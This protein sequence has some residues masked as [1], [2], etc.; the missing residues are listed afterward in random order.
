VSLPTLTRGL[1][2]V[3]D[4][5][6]NGVVA[7]AQQNAAAPAVAISAVF[8]AGSFHDPLRLPGLAYLTSLVIDRGTHRRSAD[9]IAEALDDRGVSLRVSVTRH[10]FAVSCTCLSEDFAE[11]LSVI[12]DIVRH[13]T[14]P[15][16]ELEKRRAEAITAVRQDADSTATR[17]VEALMT[18]LYGEDHA[19]ARPSRGTLESLSAITRE[20]LTAF[21]ERHIGPSG[22]RIVVA[23]DLDPVVATAQVARLFADWRTASS[24]REIVPPPPVG[25]RH[26]EVIAMPGKAQSDIAYGFTSVRRLD[27]RYYA[28]WLLNNILGE[29]GLGGRLADNIRERQGMAYYAFSSLDATVGEGPLVVRAGVDPSNVERTIEAIDT[30]VSGLGQDGPTVAELEASQDAVI[31]S[32]PRMLETN[33]GIADFLQTAEFFGLGLDYDRRLPELLRAV[34]ID[35]VRHAAREI[36]RVDRAAVAIAGPHPAGERL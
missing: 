24:E 19:Y 35:D 7:I 36:L 4:V 12:A 33:E 1:S 25:Q 9:A 10:G 8:P 26:V 5:L 20:D 6:A 27:P 32:I 18:L 23:G 21:H 11:L 17:S 14:F 2:P 16:A 29:F 15:A 31:G 3:R 22:A 34:T 28:Y 13:P 30:E